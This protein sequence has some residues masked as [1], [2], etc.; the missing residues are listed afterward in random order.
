MAELRLTGISIGYDNNLIYECSNP[1]V[2]DEFKVF[3]EPGEVNRVDKLLLWFESDGRH[4]FLTAEPKI[5]Q[6]CN[7]EWIVRSED[8]PGFSFRHSGDKSL[9]DEIESGV[10]SVLERARTERSERM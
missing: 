9:Y 5:F 1:D 2:M 10:Y 8:I 4:I 7:D 3:L 6:E